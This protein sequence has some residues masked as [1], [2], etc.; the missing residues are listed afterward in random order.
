MLCKFMKIGVSRLIQMLSA[1]AP[2]NKPTG[3][4]K[5]VVR[6]VFHN[7]SLF[8]FSLR[9]SHV[10][11]CPFRKG[12]RQ[13]SQSGGEGRWRPREG[14]ARTMPSARL[15]HPPPPPPPPPAGCVR[16]GA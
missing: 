1:V 5:K 10:C 8:V 13:S 2:G 3:D 12:L 4:K 6:N 7:F 9:F 15:L 14:V 11:Q 16:L